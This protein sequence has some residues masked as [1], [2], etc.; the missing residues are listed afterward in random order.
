MRTIRIL[1]LDDGEDSAAIRPEL[2]AFLGD[3]V[4]EWRSGE[5]VRHGL[6]ELASWV[7]SVVIVDAHVSDLKDFEV[8]ERFSSSGTP[9][10]VKSNGKNMEI[11][12]A[13]MQIGVFAYVAPVYRDNAAEMLGELILQA[14]SETRFQGLN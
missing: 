8:L 5:S 4:I 1:F 7:P 13:V 2:E 3:R 9:V 14:I 10:I 6:Y 11:E 12:R